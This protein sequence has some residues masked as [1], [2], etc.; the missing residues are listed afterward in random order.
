MKTYITAAFVGAGIGNYYWPGWNWFFA[1]SV[2]MSASDG[3]ITAAIYF[4]GA[5]VIWYMRE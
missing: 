2:A 4:V 1:D 5:A 3:R